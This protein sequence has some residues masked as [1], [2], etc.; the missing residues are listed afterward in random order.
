LSPCRYIDILVTLHPKAV[1]KKGFTELL[2]GTI[3]DKEIRY[4]SPLKG[5]VGVL[6]RSLSDKS[7]EMMTDYIE[8]R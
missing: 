3:S 6:W 2:G 4:S 8:G 7:I 5:E 1:E